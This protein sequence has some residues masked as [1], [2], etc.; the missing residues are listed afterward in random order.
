MFS[1]LVRVADLIAQQAGQKGLFIYIHFYFIFILSFICFLLKSASLASFATER[2]AGQ[3]SGL[4]T[5]WRR[6]AK[7]FGFR[8]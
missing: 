2:Q 6:V 5:H 8:V 7:D 4:R 1:V 3:T